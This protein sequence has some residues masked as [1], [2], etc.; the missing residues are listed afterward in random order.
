MG[1][2]HHNQANEHIHNSQKFPCKPFYP[3]LPSLT[4]ILRQPQI[5]FLLLQINLYYFRILNKWNHTILILFFTLVPF[6]Q[7]NGS[8]VL[9]RVSIVH[10][11]LLMNSIVRIYHNLRTPSPVDSLLVISS[12]CLLQQDW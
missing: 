8:S 11:P 9:L 10:L 6:T 5:C 2:H 7:Y 3:S 1:N 12:F 4:Q